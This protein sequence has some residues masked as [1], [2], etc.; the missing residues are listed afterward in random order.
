MCTGMSTLRGV[1]ADV[2]RL[3]LLRESRNWANAGERKVRSDSRPMLR[4]VV[5]DVS[6]LKLL[7]ESRNWASAEER[8]VRSD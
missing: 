8:K 3:E 5:A 6:R 4:G 1:V 7:W 2:S